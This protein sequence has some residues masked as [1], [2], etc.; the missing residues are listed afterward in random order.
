[1]KISE[2][3][4]HL[5]KAQSK[6][7]DVEVFA[8]DGS[9]EDFLVAGM[10]H[11]EKTK[12]EPGKILLIPLWH[13]DEDERVEISS[14]PPRNP[15]VTVINKGEEVDWELKLRLLSLFV[16]FFSLVVYLSQCLSG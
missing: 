9:F 8:Y 15:N 11:R 14:V 7:G 13:G 3:T 12:G 5:N 4:Q 6:W 2:L 10:V 1:M 16:I